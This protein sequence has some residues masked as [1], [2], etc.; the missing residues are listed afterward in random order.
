MSDFA[1]NLRYYRKRKKYSQKDLAEKLNYGYTA[2][3][4]Y[5][6]GRNEPCLDDLIALAKILEVTV[7]ELIGV[8]SEILEQEV[9]SAFKK[10]DTRSKKIIT[11]LLDVLSS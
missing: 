4:N 6:S 7:D 1:K 8:K 11:E 5:E 2:I 9:L 10:I 3:A